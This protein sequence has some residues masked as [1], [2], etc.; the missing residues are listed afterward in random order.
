MVHDQLCCQLSDLHTKFAPIHTP[1]EEMCEYGLCFMNFFYSVGFASGACGHT[2][3]TISGSQPPP[4]Y[5]G[6][7]GFFTGGWEKN[8]LVTLARGRL[9]DLGT[10]YIHSIY[11]LFQGLYRIALFSK[12][13]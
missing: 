10:L 13:V 3:L 1:N 12:G 4:S 5:A 8:I 7:P 11:G 9:Q 2:P 6:Q